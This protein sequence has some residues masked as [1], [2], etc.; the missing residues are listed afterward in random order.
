MTTMGGKAM[1]TNTMMRN[2]LLLGAA[3]GAA[4]LW[5]AGCEL[6]SGPEKAP[7]DLAVTEDVVE[8]DTILSV[9]RPEPVGELG[10]VCLEQW[11]E[12]GA[13]PQPDV[14]CYSGCGVVAGICRLLPDNRIGCV[15][16]DGGQAVVLSTVDDGRHLEEASYG[17]VNP[18]QQAECAADGTLLT[19]PICPNGGWQVGTACVCSS[20]PAEIPLEGA[21]R[22]F[23]SLA[24]AAGN[25][26]FAGI[27]AGDHDGKVVYGALQRAGG[28]AGV[29]FAAELPDSP[30]TSISKLQLLACAMNPKEST[31][32]ASFLSQ[33]AGKPGHRVTL[34]ALR[35]PV[36]TVSQ[37]HPITVPFVVPGLPADISGYLL[38]AAPDGRL[39]LQVQETGSGSNGNVNLALLSALQPESPFP[40]GVVDKTPASP[41]RLGAVAVVQSTVF[42]FTLGDPS[43][44]PAAGELRVQAWNVAQNGLVEAS[45][46]AAVLPV[47]SEGTVR[48]ST[49]PDAMLAACSDLSGLVQAAEVTFSPETGAFSIRAGVPGSLG[50]GDVADAQCG[51]DALSVVRNVISPAGVADGHVSVADRD[52][53]LLVDAP[54]LPAVALPRWAVSARHAWSHDPAGLV[55]EFTYLMGSPELPDGV[56]RPHAATTGFPLVF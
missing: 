37:I 30:F 33:D 8:A 51:S 6:G 32:I 36:G 7:M 25:L 38:E 40:T 56:G 14:T 41:A 55:L 42:S 3:L 20:T 12:M 47:C 15:A 21:F 19:S 50:S 18:C 26:L 48:V 35:A 22:E 54:I 5:M 27:G 13:L 16:D 23:V 44:E 1:K 28:D 53:I 45:A 31:F 39:V 43:T 29:A 4:G 24:D 17:K 2:T 9:P 11:T 46:S 52:F 49:C 10:Q 34:S